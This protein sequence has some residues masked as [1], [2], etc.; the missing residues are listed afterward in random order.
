[1]TDMLPAPTQLAA[2]NATV[3]QGGLAT[4]SN[5]QV[6]LMTSNSIYVICGV[7]NLHIM[8]HQNRRN[9]DFSGILSTGKEILPIFFSGMTR[10]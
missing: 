8:M 6:R 4:A 3:H 9:I 2:S 10:K 5:A 7:Y 1:M